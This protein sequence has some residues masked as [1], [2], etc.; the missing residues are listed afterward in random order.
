MFSKIAV[1]LV[2]HKAAWWRVSIATGPCSSTAWC[3][4]KRLL[5]LL[6]RVVSVAIEDDVLDYF[7]SF[8][9][10]SVM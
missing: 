7:D 8:V 1:R 5:F 6:R 3:A 9:A 10:D 2:E 4:I